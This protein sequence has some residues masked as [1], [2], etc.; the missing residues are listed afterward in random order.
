MPATTPTPETVYEYADQLPNP[1]HGARMTEIFHWIEREF[2]AV[3]G[4]IAWKQPMFVSHDT[5]IIGFSA[6][7][8]HMSVSPEAYAMPIF[9]DAIEAAGYSQSSHL[10]RIKWDEPVDYDLLAAMIRFK[11]T[12]KADYT[13]FWKK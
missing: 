1:E 5:F 3:H 6:S 8:G 7:K 10:F 12:D 9:H 11:C 13:T 2:P 4:K